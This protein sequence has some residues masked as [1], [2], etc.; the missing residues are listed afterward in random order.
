M[1]AKTHHTAVA[2][3]PPAEAW[4]PIQAIRRVHDR[5]ICRWM[6]HINVL[7]PFRPRADF[8]VVLP[9]LAAACAPVAPFAVTLNEFR[10][11]LHGSGRCTLWLA[12][13]PGGELRRLQARLQ[14]LH[15]EYSR[16]MLG[17]VQRVLV[18]GPAR[19]NA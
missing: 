7:Y 4:E 13:E 11:F 17:T 14:E 3:V 12:P 6:P 1:P 18:E 10:L 5:Q 19:R 15:D 16:A 8:P 2:I 9:A